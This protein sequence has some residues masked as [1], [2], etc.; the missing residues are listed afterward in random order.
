MP[1]IISGWLAL[2]YGLTYAS[3]LQEVSGGTYARTVLAL[4]GTAQGGLTQALAAIPAASVPAGAQ[5]THGAIF[6]AQAA[7]SMLMHWRWTGPLP[8]VGAAFPARTIS[9]ALLGNIAA[10]L[11]GGMSQRFDGGSQIGTINGE[12]LIAGCMLQSTAQG[13]LIRFSQGEA[14]LAID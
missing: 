10:P 14:S 12:P 11:T 9:I 4:T 5:V 7:G 2:G 8:R 3:V 1:S 13:A 6:D